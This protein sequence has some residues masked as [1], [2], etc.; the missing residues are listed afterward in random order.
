MRHRFRWRI[1]R[2]EQYLCAAIGTDPV[3]KRARSVS[4]PRVGDTR[5]PLRVRVSLEQ[6]PLERISK[7][8]VSSQGAGRAYEAWRDD[9]HAGLNPRSLRIHAGPAPEVGESLCCLTLEKSCGDR[10]LR[11][12]GW[13][14][15]LLFIC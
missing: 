10:A 8:S 3:E 4:P 2:G 13:P 15:L 5:Q 9:A 7:K 11:E 1:K 12:P 14:I 6:G